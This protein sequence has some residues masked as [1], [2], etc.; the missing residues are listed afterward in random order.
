MDRRQNDSMSTPLRGLPR[1]FIEWSGDGP[2]DL[3]SEELNKF[4]NVL[5]LSTGDQVAILPGDGRL[6]VCQLDGKQAIPLET[7]YPNTEP[8]LDL[9][10][11]LALSKPDSLETSIRMATELGV[12]A[13]VLFPSDRTVA[14]WDD[15]KWEKKLVRLHAIAREAAEVS[16]RT[17]LPDI[18]VKS[19]L[20]QVL[21]DL[22]DSK[23][24][25][26]QENCNFPLTL[27]GD[28]MAIVI[29]PEGGWSPAEVALIGDRA[30]TLGKRVLRV[31]TAVCSACSL[32][33][34]NR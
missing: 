4:R 10:L 3:P 25:S 15:K 21:A 24:L 18:Q 7:H 17:K 23:V 27:S 16:F 1:A 30:M 12:S 13:L 26:E 2:L 32:L 6:I 22:P 20:A 19:N 28:R 9:T 8:G 29:G 11:A 34:A 14:R 33:L 31:D 5:R